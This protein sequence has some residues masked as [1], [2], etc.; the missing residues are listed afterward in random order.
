MLPTHRLRSIGQSIWLDQITRA[1]LRKGTLRRYIEDYGVTGLT[2]NPTIFDNAIKNS[3][4]YDASIAQGLSQGLSGERLFLS[5]AI[6]D[7]REAADL[8]RPV[9]EATDGS[10][11]WVS[12]EVSPELAYD[13]QATVEAA[14]A[15]WNEAQRPN[16]FIKIPGTP[17]GLPAIEESIFRGVPVNVTLL[18]SPEHYQAA[19]AAYM[20]GIERRVEAGLSPRV[21]SVAS[22][23]VSRWDKAILGKVPER[24]RNRLGYAI[25][26]KTYRAYN[27]LLRSERWRRLEERGARPQKLLWASTGTK[28]P[29]ASDVLYVELLASPNTINTMPEET[30]LAFVDHGKVG[31]LLPA[32]GKGAEELLAEFEGA[33]VQV[34]ALAERLQKE[35]AEAFQNS[36]RAMLD[37][38]SVRAADLRAAG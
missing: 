32:D 20:R 9:F 15:L 34:A 26:L 3:R 25:A 1:L 12:L 36:W 8:F 37:R 28:D 30:L 4:D 18:F 7:L 6:E 19:A 21:A 27:E 13:T 31:E 14:Q 17:P 35:G 24:L 11:G 22:L 5:L 23:F 38:L 2:S 33:G 10:D 29:A 16:L